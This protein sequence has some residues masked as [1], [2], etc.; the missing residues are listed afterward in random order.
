M[1]V[2]GR[3]HLHGSEIPAKASYHGFSNKRRS[4]LNLSLT[5]LHVLGAFQIADR[6]TVMRPGDLHR[7]RTLRQLKLAV[8]PL[9]PI[10][11]IL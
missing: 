5:A 3:P 9:M 7:R 1:D 2:S 11:E 10:I 6:D 8:G 4:G